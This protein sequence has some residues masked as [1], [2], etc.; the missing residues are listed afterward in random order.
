MDCGTEKICIAKKKD[1][2]R[3]SKRAVNGNFCAIHAK[4]ADVDVVSPDEA[5][6]SHRPSSSKVVTTST[7]SSTTTTTRITTSEIDDKI[8]SL[9]L[10][11]NRLKKVKKNIGNEGKIITKAKWVFYNYFK[12]STI[13]LDEMR[14]R[15][16][17]GGLYITKQHVSKD[18]IITEK[19]VI[20]WIL[21]KKY[22]D[23]QFD[24]LS[25]D[26]KHNYILEAEH[27]ISEK[28]RDA[29]DL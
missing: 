9:K 8:A 11:I 17:A 5:E 20:P 22:T 14:N 2:H 13:V 3:C 29:V 21:V 1:G 7:P 28:V 18:G 16:K 27:I 24:N 19:E 26:D 10:E 15:L 12:N 4:K 6:T 23:A 25:V